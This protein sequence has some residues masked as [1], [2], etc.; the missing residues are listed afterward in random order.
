MAT[1]IPCTPFGKKM[2]VTLTQTENEALNN[3]KNLML[4]VRKK[5]AAAPAVAT[6]G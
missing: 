2:K 4:S 1:R 3:S 6:S 5:G